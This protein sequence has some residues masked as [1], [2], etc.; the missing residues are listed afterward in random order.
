MNDQ[1]SQIIQKGNML[2]SSIS[3]GPSHVWVGLRL[4]RQPRGN[5][6][7]SANPPIGDC[8]HQKLD[9]TKIRQAVERGVSLANFECSS[10][11]HLVEIVYVDDDA[12]RYDLYEVLGHRIVRAL[13]SG[14]VTEV[15]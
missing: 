2:C 15:E 9:G 7:I 4:A 12:P 6:V 5:V 1:M 10:S 3:T 14:E 11:W 8:T 13:E